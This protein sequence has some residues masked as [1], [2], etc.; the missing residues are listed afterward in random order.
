M[1]LKGAPLKAV[2]ATALLCLIWSS[3]ID[4]QTTAQTTKTPLLTI[5]SEP[6]AIVWIDEIR[7]GST[8]SSGNLAITRLNPGRHT[9]RVRADGFKE[10]TL[11]LI[12][13][14]RSV[15]VKLVTTTDKAELTFQQAE[16]AREQAKDDADREKAADLYREAIKLRAVYPAAQIGLARVL[17]DLNQFR[18]AHDAI[19]A[20]RRARPIYPEA[21]A[22]E[23]RIYREEAFE[24]EAIRSFRRSIREG[25][26]FQ[27]EAHVGLARVLEDKGQLAEAVVEFRKAIDQLSDSEPVIYQMLG[28]AYEKLEKPKDAVAAYEKYLELAPSGSYAAAI[29]SILDQLKREAAGEQIIP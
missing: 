14:R 5:T 1:S 24:D 10:T 6:N 13:G 22:I 9:V 7:R 15:V 4:A 19:D 20:A 12:P 8:D 21:S 2:L 26:G 16:M 25:N 28:A 23:G 11:P 29:R 3:S 27:P 18:K 17:M